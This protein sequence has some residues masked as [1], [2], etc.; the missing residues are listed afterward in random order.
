M[1]YPFR[2]DFMQG[3]VDQFHQTIIPPHFR[4]LIHS[5]EAYQS[6]KQAFTQAERNDWFAM[7]VMGGNPFP[8]GRRLP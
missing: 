6:M 2:H 1:T 3:A 4:P 5:L 8:H 7:Y